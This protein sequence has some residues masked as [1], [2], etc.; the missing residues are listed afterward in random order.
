MRL[1]SSIHDCDRPGEGFSACSR[2]RGMKAIAFLLGLSLTT[3]VIYLFKI[4]NTCVY[5]GYIVACIAALY[6]FTMNRQ[7][8]KIKLGFIDRSIWMFAGLTGLSL[9]PS[10]VQAAT[11]SLPAVA[12]IVVL[13][14]LAVLVCGIITYCV[15]ICLGEWTESLVKGIAIGIILNGI[16]SVVQQ[17]AFESGSFFTLCRWFP[18]GSFYVSAPWETW[19]QLPAVAEGITTYRAQGLFLE[20][21]HLSVFLVCMTPLVFLFLKNFFIK[22]LVSVSSIYCCILSYSPNIAFLIIEL[23]VLFYFAH[24]ANK[25]RRPFNQRVGALTILMAF[26]IFCITMLLVIA[27]PQLITGIFDLVESSI[28]DVNVESTTDTGTLE[29]WSSMLKAISAAFQYP[30]SAGWNTE[31]ITLQFLYGSSDVASHSFCIRLLLELG[32]LG[33][34]AY[35]YVI[36]R[37]SFP[38]LSKMNIVRLRCL[39]L[40]VIFLF[41]CQAS[42][43]TVMLPWVWALLGIARA[44]I[45]TIE[46]QR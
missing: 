31:S 27:K 20:A 22:I 36:Y 24:A 44:A 35:V 37:H 11:G 42:N 7:A 43:G 29:R 45:W 8:G 21:S 1:R 39:G 23:F 18:Q 4:G 46:P 30:F 33:V 14:G 13:K 38:L 3:N 10:L 6:L 19:G 34:I 26:F 15:V 32:I 28:S 5:I 9:V 40:A 16:L 2:D 25:G 12:P 17:L 41:V